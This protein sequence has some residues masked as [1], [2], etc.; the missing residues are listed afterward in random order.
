MEWHISSAQKKKK[1]S[2]WKYPTKLSFKIKDYWN[3][4]IFRKTRTENSLPT[5]LSL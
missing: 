3:K 4:D 5:E 2:N 1:M